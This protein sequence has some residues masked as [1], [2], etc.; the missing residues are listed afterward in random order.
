[1]S[2]NL[3]ILIVKLSSLG[4]VVHAMAA[5]QDIRRAFP[6]ARIDWVVERGFAPLVRRCKGVHRVIPCELRRWRQSLFSTETRAG[7][8]AN[9]I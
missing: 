5:L 6:Y 8:A 9:R 4:D 2:V 1:M 3:N 7:T